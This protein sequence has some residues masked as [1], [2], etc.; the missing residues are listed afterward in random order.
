MFLIHKCFLY[1]ILKFPSSI[2]HHEFHC[3]YQKTFKSQHSLN[4]ITY[5]LNFINHYHIFLCKILQIHLD[6]S[7]IKNNN[8]QTFTGLYEVTK[9]TITSPCV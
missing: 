8:I 9:A 5:Y 1:K 7:Y 2:F 3:I 6:T 4:V